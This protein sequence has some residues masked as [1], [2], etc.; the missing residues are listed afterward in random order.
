MLA[1]AERS[2]AATSCEHVQDLSFVR[3]RQQRQLFTGAAR[4]RFLCVC[5]CVCV[6]G[7][8]VNVMQGSGSQLYK[9]QSP[10]NH[11]SP[12]TGLGELRAEP[13]KLL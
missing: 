3:D 2:L 4:F 13:D 11:R 1:A 6:C 12:S 8:R 9:L 5:V 7:V 10:L